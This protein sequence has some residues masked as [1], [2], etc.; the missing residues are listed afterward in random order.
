M[1]NLKKKKNFT[2]NPMSSSSTVVNFFRQLTLRTLV[3]IIVSVVFSLTTL[4]SAS[5]WTLRALGVNVFVPFGL[6]TFRS[7]NWPLADVALL[8]SCAYAALE[9]AGEAVRCVRGG[10]AQVFKDRLM[11]PTVGGLAFLAQGVFG[12]YIDSSNDSREQFGVESHE[13]QPAFLNFWFVAWGA[14]CVWFGACGGL[15]VIDRIK[16]TPILPI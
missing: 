3:L 8:L 4:G 11:G 5:Y 15:T 12:F 14:F 10:S 13:L 1:K 9:A 16:S 2:T 6:S 7:L